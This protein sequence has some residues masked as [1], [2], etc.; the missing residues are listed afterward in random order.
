MS[1]TL[2]LPT[3]AADL[4]GFL[5]LGDGQS[6]SQAVPERLTIRPPLRL[7]DNILNPSV[8]SVVEAAASSILELRDLHAN[9]D[10]HGA[11]AI[12]RDTLDFAVEL[13]GRLAMPLTPVPSVVPTVAGGVQLE[14]HTLAHHVELEIEGRD[15]F[16]LFMAPRD[17]QQE[18][19][20][21]ASNDVSEARSGLARVF[22]QG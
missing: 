4:T 22:A 14:W 8:V 10:G 5:D 21:F 13:F 15:R 19:E 11:A 7:F 17:L 1:A 20:Y 6:A 16:S 18:P 3:D 12:D 9:W 2:L